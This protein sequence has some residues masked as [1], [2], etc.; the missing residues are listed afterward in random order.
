LIKKFLEETYAI[1]LEQES[2]FN[3]INLHI[4][5]CDNEIQSDICIHT[6]KELD[7][8]KENFEVKGF[9]GTDFRPAFEYVNAL[10]EQKKFNRLNGMLYF[11]DGN[12]IYPSKKPPFQ[13]AFI[14]VET[15]GELKKVPPWAIKLEIM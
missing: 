13:V 15:K 10:I 14:F 1:L 5:Q 3:K 4:I 9:G 11:T 2:F 8:Y 7:E 6:R 12:G